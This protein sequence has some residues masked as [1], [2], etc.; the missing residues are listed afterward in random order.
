MVRWLFEG[1]ALRSQ[2]LVSHHVDRCPF[3]R[4]TVEDTIREALVELFWREVGRDDGWHEVGMATPDDAVEVGGE[5]AAVLEIFGAEVIKDDESRDRGRGDRISVAV[6]MEEPGAEIGPVQE[7]S[8]RLSPASER[9]GRSVAFADACGAAQQEA[10]A[11]W[12][13]GSS[14]GARGK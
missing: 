1:M 3:L 14:E 4:E 8:A 13:F 2:A 10:S 5:E 7:M 9:C 12:G 6:V 11:L